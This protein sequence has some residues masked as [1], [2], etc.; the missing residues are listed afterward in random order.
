MWAIQSRKKLDTGTT[1]RQEEDGKAR[2]MLDTEKALVK[3]WMRNSANSLTPGHDRGVEAFAQISREL[4]DLVFAI[5][6]DGLARG[7]EDDL[8][9]VAFA[10]MGL[11]FGE[12]LG[13][14][15]AVEVV[16]KLLEEIGAGHGLGPS[17]SF[18]CVPLFDEAP[19]CRK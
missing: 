10:D 13:L 6:G 1:L 7:I 15:L 4:V 17:F 5:D 3:C 2:R 11:D 9:V 16:R 18:F 8:A 19:F 14:D 12:E